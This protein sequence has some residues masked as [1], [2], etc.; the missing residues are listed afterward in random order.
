VGTTVLTVHEAVWV[1]W[2]YYQCPRCK[3]SSYPLDEKLDW[4]GERQTPVVREWLTRL[5]A[6]EPYD[7]TRATLKELTGFSI[8][9]KTA[10][11]ITLELGTL[12]RQH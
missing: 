4:D 6:S 3:A 11:S 7:P 12:L 1:Q 8:A 5:T 10:E 2:D 9:H